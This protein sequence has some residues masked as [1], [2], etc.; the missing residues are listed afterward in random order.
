MASASCKWYFVQVAHVSGRF[1]RFADCLWFFYSHRLGGLL[2]YYER[3][4]A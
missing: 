1:F 3:E 2:K 4:A